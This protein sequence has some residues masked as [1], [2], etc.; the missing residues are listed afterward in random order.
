MVKRNSAKNVKNLETLT[1]ILNAIATII[2][3]L[4]VDGTKFNEITVK[5]AFNAR[6]SLMEQKSWIIVDS[7]NM[8]DIACGFVEFLSFPNK[9]VIELCNLYNIQSEM[10]VN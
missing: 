4:Y 2:S 5:N 9:D 7:K 8:A 10:L 3:L 1:I 6:C